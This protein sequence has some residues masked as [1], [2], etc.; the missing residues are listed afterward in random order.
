VGSFF[1]VDTS[2]LMRGAGRILY[3][4]SS[5]DVPQAIADVLT[6]DTGAT[7]FDPVS[8]TGTPSPGWFDLGAT[9]QGIT[10][11]VNN[12]ETSF[13]IDQVQGA[14]GTQPDSWTCTLATRLA[15]M[16]LEHMVFAWEGV[17]ITT[18]ATPTVPERKTSFAGATSYTER[19]LAVAFMKPTGALMLYSFHRAVRAP[20]AGQIVFQKTGNAMDLAV[21]F[22]I[23]ADATV[24]DPRGQFFDVFEQTP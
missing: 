19:K 13:D 7:E 23:L 8:I 3:A 12:T 11:E 24:T 9:T 21:Q 2:K 15:E 1:R 17:P 18:N 5:A 4:D 22:N 16:T 6:L 20:Q 14:V 10:V